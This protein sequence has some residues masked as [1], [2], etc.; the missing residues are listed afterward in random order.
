MKHGYVENESFRG[1]ILVAPGYLKNNTIGLP[2]HRTYRFE[3]YKSSILR[4]LIDR[5]GVGVKT[6]SKSEELGF[7]VQVQ[8][9][10][11]M[12]SASEQYINQFRGA[13]LGV[14]G[15]FVSAID[16]MNTVLDGISVMGYAHDLV[17]GGGGKGMPE[18][19]RPSG[20]SYFKDHQLNGR[21]IVNLS[22]YKGEKKGWIDT[23]KNE[24]S[25]EAVAYL[26][27]AT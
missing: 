26:L 27:R 5:R 20:F 4:H 15:G 11:V 3:G 1:C 21:M 22:A 10:N 12:K 2:I 16:A 17:G 23:G 9:A 18:L 24:T 6:D 14:A 19:K 13:A 25:L 8:I 7:T